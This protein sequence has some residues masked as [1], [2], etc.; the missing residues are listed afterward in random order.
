MVISV[1]LESKEGLTAPSSGKLISWTVGWEGGER[2]LGLKRPL[3]LLTTFKG[4]L[5]LGGNSMKK[6][7]KT[8]LPI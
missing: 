5:S 3:T 7:L 4:G 8:V 2:G 1:A 6:R